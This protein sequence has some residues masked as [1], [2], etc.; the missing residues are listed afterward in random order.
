VPR[1]KSA[2]AFWP[3]ARVDGR[4]TRD[5][6]LAVR[7]ASWRCFA[8]L[9]AHF[10]D[11]F[12][13]CEDGTVPRS[14]CAAL[15]P[16]TNKLP[17]NPKKTPNLKEFPS[18]ITGRIRGTSYILFAGMPSYSRVSPTKGSKQDIHGS[19][20]SLPA[21]SA[22]MRVR[23]ALIRSFCAAPF[24]LTRPSFRHWGRRYTSTPL[25]E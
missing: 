19:T 25:F 21:P 14:A 5:G 2:L 16:E 9:R 6:R 24:D 15:G 10:D 13:E 7:T 4:G 20:P 3:M 11:D 18:D 17:P 22:L 23:S 1:L 12:L 8:S